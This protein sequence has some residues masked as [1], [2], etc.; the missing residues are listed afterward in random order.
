M[1][2]SN[3][4][5][6]GSDALGSGASAPTVGALAWRRW[7]RLFCAVFAAGLALLYLF[8]VV[9]DPFSTGRF[10]VFSGVDI[11]FSDLSFA[12]AGRARDLRFDVAIIGNSH[13]AFEP[14]RLSEVSGHKFVLL[15]V[16]GTA[17]R[18]QLA[19]ARSFVRHHRGRPVGLLWVL[20]YLWCVPEGHF[21]FINIPDFP[22]WLYD[23]ANL[24]YLRNIFQM[25]SVQASFHRLAIRLFNAPQARR[26]D[27]YADSL[28]LPPDRLARAIGATRPVADPAPGA[29]FRSAELMAA[30]AAELDP[31]TSL[32]FV[33]LPNYVSFLPEPGSPAADRLAA[34]KARFRAIADGHP[35]GAFIDRMVDDDI[36]RDPANF[37]DATHARGPL[38]RR[39]EPELAAVIR[40]LMATP[41]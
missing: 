23:S 8:V 28:E 27:G 2:I 37:M 14:S 19:M 41:R 10:T 33:F 12:N 30:F 24:E 36:A 18:E 16:A 25:A 13:A 15:S 5:T 34:C 21:G 32:V 4:S 11:A 1:R 38:M 6:S 17:A 26:S 39:L 22:Y 40:N 29:P 20:D 31:Q 3:S 9:T 7:V 35:R